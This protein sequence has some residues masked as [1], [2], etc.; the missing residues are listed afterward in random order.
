MERN[1]VNIERLGSVIHQWVV[2]CMA[3]LSQLLKRDPTP[4]HPNRI[5]GRT[6]IGLAITVSILGLRCLTQG[7]SNRSS[8][9]S[10]HALSHNHVLLILISSFL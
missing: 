8:H 4:L 5:K 3:N 6:Y 1:I 9:V 7:S 10:S 2:Q